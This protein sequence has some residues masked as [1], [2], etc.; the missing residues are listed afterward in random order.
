MNLQDFTV[1][2][3]GK[4]NI[5]ISI[6]VTLNLIFFISSAVSDKELKLLIKDLMNSQFIRWKTSVEDYFIKLYICAL[7]KSAIFN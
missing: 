2:V 6:W 7:A 4:I 1:L 3:K 5:L